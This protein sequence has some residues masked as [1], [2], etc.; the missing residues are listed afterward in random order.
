MLVRKT[1]EKKSS[2]PAAIRT[3]DGNRPGNRHKLL[4]A[5]KLHE[6]GGKRLTAVLD[7]SKLS[8]ADKNQL[9]CQRK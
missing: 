4:E 9:C 2:P 6:N 8:T 5:P 3:S 7:L 1:A